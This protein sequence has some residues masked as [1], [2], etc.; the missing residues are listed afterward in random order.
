MFDVD[1]S[2]KFT[3]SEEELNLGGVLEYNFLLFLD[4]KNI[5]PTDPSALPLKE[6]FLS[7]SYVGL[8]LIEQTQSKLLAQI[9][10]KLKKS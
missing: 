2:P 8:S 3:W 5:S 9:I 1:G 4:S 7:G 10:E 6:A